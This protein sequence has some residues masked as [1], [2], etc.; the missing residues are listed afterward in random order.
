MGFVYLVCDEGGVRGIFRQEAS[1][2]AKVMEIAKNDYDIDINI[3]PFD[4]ASPWRC[5]YDVVY[6]RKEI[7]ND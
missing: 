3:A 7:L 1:A 5:G 6:W 4:F 2:L